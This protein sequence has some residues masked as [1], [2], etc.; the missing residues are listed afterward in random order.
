MLSTSMNGKYMDVNVTALLT[1]SFT[2]ETSLKLAVLVLQWSERNADSLISE[3]LRILSILKGVPL[4]LMLQYSDLPFFG[5]MLNSLKRVC[6]DYDYHS[7]VSYSAIFPANAWD[8]YHPA[9]SGRTGSQTDLTHAC[10]NHP[11]ND[12]TGSN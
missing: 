6:W 12:V 4:S 3:R 9:G 11:L 2:S 1:Y 7:C 8:R 10:L 5:I